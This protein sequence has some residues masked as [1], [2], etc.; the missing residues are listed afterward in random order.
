M[1]MIECLVA[2]YCAIVLMSCVVIGVVHLYTV[3]RSMVSVLYT[4]SSEWLAA[5]KLARDIR[6][7]PRRR[8]YW[9]LGVGHISWHRNR[10][11]H[12]WYCW[13]DKL[14]FREGGG[15]SSADTTVVSVSGSMD[16]Q[17]DVVRAVSLRLRCRRSM[18]DIA[19]YIPLYEKLF[20]CS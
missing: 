12:T 20:L 16:A 14:L 1:T 10:S 5:V 7:G 11:M 13:G 3:R 9:T 8:E 17:G 15:V 18:G 2:W 4:V 19:I 6:Q